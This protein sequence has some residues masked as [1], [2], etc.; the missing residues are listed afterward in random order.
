MIAKFE[1]AVYTPDAL[2]AGNAHLLVSRRITLA[3]GQNL[4]RGA[5][6]GQITASGKYVL[7]LSAAA[8]GSEIPDL[9]LAEDTDATAGDKATIAYERGDFNTHGLTLGAGHTVASIHEGLRAK[10]PSA[11]NRPATS[12]CPTTRRAG[13][14]KT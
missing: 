6:L 8:D 9:I 12:P 4:T 14:S 7:S 5:V 10:G 11:T 1:S 3:S 2:V 13:W